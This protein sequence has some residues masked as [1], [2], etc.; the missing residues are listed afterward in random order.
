MKTF[1]TFSDLIASTQ[2]KTESTFVC[3]ERA[4]AK[5]VLQATGYVALIGDATF[6]NGRVAKLQF[7]NKALVTFFASL[8]EA[9]SSGYNLEPVGDVTINIPSFYTDWVTPFSKIISDYTVTINIETGHQITTGLLLSDKDYSNFIISSVDAEVTVGASFSSGSSVISV[10]NGTSPV[11][12]TLIN[13]DNQTNVSSYNLTGAATGFINSG[14]GMKN[15]GDRG[16]HV[17]NASNCYADGCVFTGFQAAGV[18]VSRASTLQCANAVLTGNSQNASNTFGAMYASRGSTIHAPDVNASGSGADGVRVQRL[19]T[20]VVPNINLSNTTGITFVVNG[21]FIFSDSGSPTLTNLGGQLIVAA[22]G[23]QIKLGVATITFQAGMT[24][25]AI[26]CRDSRVIAD[27]I[28]MSGQEGIG[29]FAQ[30]AN[31]IVDI[32]GASITGGTVSV[33]AADAA[34]VNA[35]G[36]TLLNSTTTR[37]NATSGARVFLEDA[38]ITG[39]SNADITVS[40][41]SWVVATGATTSNGTG[42]P[43][44]SDTNMSA[45]FNFVNNGNKGFLWV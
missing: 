5:Y 40:K 31:A 8:Q 38:T 33:W 14:A 20:I 37:V 4:N 36:A 1:N 28:I 2:T 30:G 42:T 39:A 26:D 16:L 32:S 3:T 9:C 43:A 7:E 29:V 13:V 24:D 15:G 27:G 17:Q 11:L 23:G 21:G 22:S 34:T 12:N 19:S 25:E 41:G 10:V 6:A 44:V 35:E 45:G 18:H